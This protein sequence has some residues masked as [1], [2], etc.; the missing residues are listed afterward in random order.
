M[1]SNMNRLIKVFIF[2]V[3]ISLVIGTATATC[4]VVVIT[5]PTG[6]DPN[7]AAAGSMSWAANMFQSTFILSK[8][9]HFGVLSG[10]EGQSTPRLQAIVGTLTKLEN[11]ASPSEA[12]STASSYSGI[13]VMVGTATQG[14]AVGGD[15]NVYLVTVSN[16]GTI[17]V[18]PYANGG[19]AVLPA[20]TKGAIIHLRN[21]EG[22]PQA[23]TADTV[24]RE[25]AVNIGKMIRD[26]YNATYIVGKA[27]EEVAIDSGEKHGGGGINL[28]SGVTTG[29][30]FTPENLNETGYSMDAAFYKVCPTDGWRVSYPEADNYQTCP[31]DGTTLKTVYA[32]DAL[33]DAIT[34]S[35]NSLSVSTYGTDAAGISETTEEIVTASVKK[36]GYSAD[37][38]SKDINSAIDNGLLVGVN[39]VEP[40]DINV[41]ANSK[42]VGVYY[43]QLADHRTSPTWNLPVS[44]SFLNI[45]GNIQTAIG[46]ILVLLVL[47]RS[48]LIKSFLKKR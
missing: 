17:T 24:R 8:E 33:I 32:Y 39:Y 41:K 23:G 36:H 10:G 31:N 20:G 37:E 13:R 19:L 29:D 25:T 11:G 35:N 14:A 27:M 5:D 9:K 34:V 16:N 12:A 2:L 47:F 22:N 46:L 45:V 30:M 40:K 26:G 38:I 6:T 44:S 1:K 7:G 43:K 48:T 18:T 15:F 3:T 21:S 4:N 42:A 28:V